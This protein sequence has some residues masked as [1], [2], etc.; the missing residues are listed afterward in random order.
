V[1]DI[2]EGD[3]LP[4]GKKSYSVSFILQDNEKTLTDAIID[5]TMGKLMNSFETEIGAVIRK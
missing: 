2:Y 1:F 4:E 5:K 3:K